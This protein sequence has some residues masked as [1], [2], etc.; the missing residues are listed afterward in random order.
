MSAAV[1][2]S[3]FACMDTYAHVSKKERQGE[4]EQEA[5]R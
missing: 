5:S 4:M 2:V 1:Y 3:V